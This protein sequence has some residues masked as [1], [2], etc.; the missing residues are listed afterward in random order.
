MPLLCACNWA[1]PN[2][3]QS[4]LR[5]WTPC[6][7][8]MLLSCGESAHEELHFSDHFCE[9]VAH[10]RAPSQLGTMTL[11]QRWQGPDVIDMLLSWTAAPP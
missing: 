4:P 10:S 11:V 9:P 2:L 6:H 5:C 8:H 3:A 1:T 7:P